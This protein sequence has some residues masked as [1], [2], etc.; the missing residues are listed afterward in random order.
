MENVYAIKAHI[1]SVESTRK[2]TRSMKLV[3]ASKLHRVQGQLSGFTY[4][5]DSCRRALDVALSGGEDGP[6]LRKRAGDGP[7]RVCYV[8]FVGSRGLCG[9]YNQELM[10]CLRRTVAEDPGDFRCVI[11]GRWHPETE[12]DGSLRL[13][14]RFE[15]MGDVPAPEDGAALSEYLKGLFL[16]GDFD[17]VVLL[18]QKHAHMSQ[19]PESLQLLPLRR[20]EGA[21]AG[22]EVIFEPDRRTLVERLCNMYTGACVRRV[23][24][25]SRL[26]EHYARMTAMTAATDN[27]E[28]LERELSL[29]MNRT[30]QAK[31]TTELSEI[32]GGSKA[33]GRSEARD[34]T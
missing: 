8:A 4:Y 3:S 30:R 10:D 6:L 26:S 16:S 33:L 18:Y 22:R 20:E 23:L 9:G 28:K 14:R 21:G 32:V 27:A 34:A 31:I 17:R 25:E 7:D 24:L 29:K 12:E 2:I 1:K 15:D 5:A 19:S 11:C 13:L